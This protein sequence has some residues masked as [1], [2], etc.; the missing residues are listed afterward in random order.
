[1]SHEWQDE[2]G[3]RY[4]VGPA[5][6]RRDLVVIC[7]FDD[8]GREVGSIKILPEA[9]NELRKYLHKEGEADV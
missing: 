6:E 5:Q 4:V 8:L 9:W 7:Y 3:Y 1:M 2:E